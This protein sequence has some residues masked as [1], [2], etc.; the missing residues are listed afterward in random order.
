MP[1][2]PKGKGKAR[3]ELEQQLLDNGSLPNSQGSDDDGY[4]FG[5]SFVADSEPHFV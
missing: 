5:M 1:S 3:A 4:V 2:R